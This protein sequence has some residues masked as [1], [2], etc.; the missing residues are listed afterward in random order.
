MNKQT[1]EFLRDMLMFLPETTNDFLKSIDEHG[2]ILVTVIIEGI[3]MP[4][5]ILLLKENKNTQLI[6]SIFDYFEEISNCNDGYFINSIFSVTVLEIL[7][8]DKN[9]LRTAKEYMGPTTTQLQIEADRGLG[10]S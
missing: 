2:E 5:I 8:N 10:R 1:D 4:E 3:F 7:G 6:E 9:I